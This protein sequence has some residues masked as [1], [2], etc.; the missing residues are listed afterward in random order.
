MQVFLSALNNVSLSP[1]EQ[2]VLRTCC[3]LAVPPPSPGSGGI[4]LTPQL[5]LS[6]V[7]LTELVVTVQ[8][9]A[10]GMGVLAGHVAE[11]R[12]VIT[13]HP[14]PHLESV[15]GVSPCAKLRGLLVV[16]GWCDTQVRLSLVY[17]SGNLLDLRYLGSL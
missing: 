2:H 1:G 4:I 9:L 14:L 12:G 17:V 13:S 10:S 16:V 6:S 11:N 8:D 15:S 3:L 7:S 5:D